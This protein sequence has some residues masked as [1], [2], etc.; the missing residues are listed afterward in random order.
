MDGRYEMVVVVKDP[1]AYQ[2]AT[3]G[4][5]VRIAILTKGKPTLMIDLDESL[6]KMADEGAVPGGTE[7]ALEDPPVDTAAAAGSRH[8]LKEEAVVD[9][10]ALE[11]QADAYMDDLA[12]RMKN[13][14]TL[15][16]VLNVEA[17]ME[18]EKAGWVSDGSQMGGEKPRSI[19]GV[20]TYID[21][22]IPGLE[23]EDVDNKG[24]MVLDLNNFI[25]NQPVDNDNSILT[26]QAKPKNKAPTIASL[27]TEE[28]ALQLQID[29]LK[30][31]LQDDMLKEVL[32]QAI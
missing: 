30:A 10:S 23:A 22:A 19:A 32:Q 16:I 25:P 3:D 13:P 27:T 17:Q 4:R 5:C 24:D 11:L 21:I 8:T 15:I 28:S 7:T 6:E 2:S 1:N 12:M 26:E 20:A 18:A 14:W 9:Q 31:G 29:D